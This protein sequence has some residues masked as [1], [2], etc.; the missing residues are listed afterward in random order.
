MTDIDLI[1]NDKVYA[2][3]ILDLKMANICIR[4]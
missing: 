3:A 4:L 2:T 1:K